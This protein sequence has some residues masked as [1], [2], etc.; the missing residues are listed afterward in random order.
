MGFLQQIS[1]IRFRLF[2]SHPII[3]LNR[4]NHGDRF[5][6]ALNQDGFVVLC[7][8]L[9]Q[10]AKMD[11]GIGS[12]YRCKGYVTLSLLINQSIN[13]YSTP[14]SSNRKLVCAGWDASHSTHQL[15]E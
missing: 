1:P 4:Q 8:P 13:Q 15:N 7:D 12:S 3:A 14:S 10:F 9:Q 2:Q 5:A 6:G 11:A